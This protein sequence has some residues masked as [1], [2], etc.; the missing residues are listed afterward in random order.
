MIYDFLIFEKELYIYKLKMDIM[1]K[2]R[3]NQINSKRQNYLKNKTLIK[4]RRDKKNTP[5]KY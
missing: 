1:V 2:D 4:I 3:E 5:D